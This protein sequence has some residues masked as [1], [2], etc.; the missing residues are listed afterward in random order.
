MSTTVLYVVMHRL[1]NLHEQDLSC[2]FISTVDARL[3]CSDVA[4]AVMLLAVFDIQCIIICSS[5]AVVRPHQ[6]TLYI[7]SW[8]L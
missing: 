6:I 1:C 3:S 4:F 2:M 8:K 7:W 5:D